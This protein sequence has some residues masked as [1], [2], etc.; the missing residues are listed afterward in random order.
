MTL[1][2]EQ[3]NILKNLDREIYREVRRS[4]IDMV[5]ATDMT[6]H[7]EHLAKFLQVFTKQGSMDEGDRNSSRQGS[8]SDQERSLIETL[9]QSP[10]ISAISTPE[11]LVLIKRMLIKCADVSNPARPLEL[12]KTWAHR[13][14]EEYCCQVS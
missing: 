14:A 10:N 6:K 5:L 3:V 9:S 1:A 4:I 8:L 11:N 7:F 13:I 2:D 12:C